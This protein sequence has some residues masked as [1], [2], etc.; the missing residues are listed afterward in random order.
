MTVY[1]FHII[2]P[3][4][5]HHHSQLQQSY[6]KNCGTK[7]VYIDFLLNLKKKNKSYYI[8]FTHIGIF[9]LLQD[10][11]TS[12]FCV[13]RKNQS[14]IL[15]KQ[16]ILMNPNPMQTTRTWKK[17]ASTKAKVNKTEGKLACGKR[18]GADHMELTTKR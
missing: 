18:V 16:Q 1:Y 11:N 8:N 7:I 3:F 15:L 6:N 17:Q 5:F 9:S 14:P 13:S 12:L 4:L 2:P 10:L